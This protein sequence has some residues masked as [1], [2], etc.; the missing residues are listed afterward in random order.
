M[1]S[2][3]I[4]YY[5]KEKYV[6]RCITSV[7]NQTFQDFEIILVDDGSTDNGCAIIREKY[8]NKITLIS[9]KNQGVSQ[10][11][12]KGI[13]IARFNYIALLDADD[14]WHIQFLEKVKEVVDREEDV[15]IIG[16]HYSRDIQFLLRYYPTLNY[17]KFVNYFKSALRNTYFT[18]SSVVISKTFFDNNASFNS[19]LK[20]GEDIDLW[21]RAVQSGGNAFYITDTLSYYSDEDV[22]QATNRKH[23]LQ[24]TLVG[25]INQLYTG[26]KLESK[27]AD[28]NKFVS[29]YV[30]FNLYPYYFDTKYHESAKKALHNN[31]FKFYLLHLPYLLPLSIGKR[32]LNADLLKKQIRLYMKFIIRYML[33]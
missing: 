31:E 12:N 27:N 18:S 9:Q 23:E 28:F 10:A 22:F 14:C 4:P 1:F 25:N 17:F 7:L 13:S 26:L 20:S 32:V 21:L 19:S 3:I 29:I 8:G 2:V 33:K 24:H 5:N 30:Y 6:E 15:K 16:T 11:R